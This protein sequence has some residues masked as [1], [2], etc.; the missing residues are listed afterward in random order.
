VVMAEVVEHLP[1]D[2]A[3]LRRIR[4]ILKDDGALVLSVPFF[5]DA[6][7][8]HV[9]IHSPV[10]V[11]RLLHAA[12]WSVA[13]YVEKGG[14]LCSLAGWFPIA[15]T[16]HAANLITFKLAGRTFYQ[17]LNRRIA[18]FDSWLGRRRYSLHR[19]SRLYGAFIKCTK[20]APVDYVEMNV[21]AFENLGLRF[22][23][24]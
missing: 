13:D 8:T 23:R 1:N 17:P 2:F 10:S 4:E 11:E 16:V 7:P 5:Q 9:R 18:A 15:M 20:A 24:S 12:G 14:G 3:A 21:R 19:W 6:E 22:A